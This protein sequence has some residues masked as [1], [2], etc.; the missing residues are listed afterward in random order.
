[1]QKVLKMLAVFII[2][3]PLCH[4]AYWDASVGS[5]SIHRQSSNLSFELADLC[6][7]NVSGL[8]VTPS[9]RQIAGYHSRYMVVDL[10]DVAISERTSAK[11]GELRA[12]D[13]IALHSEADEDVIR[14]IIKPKDSPFFTFEFS[15]IWPVVARADRAVIYRGV[16]INDRD[17]LSNN[18]DFAGTSF[19]NSRELSKVRYSDMMLLCMNTTVVEDN[20]DFINVA[21]LPTKRLSYQID[22]FSSGITDLRYRETAPDMVTALAEGNDRYY[23][24]Y[25]LTAKISMGTLP[26]WLN[27][28][29]GLEC[30]Q[31]DERLP[32]ISKCDVFDCWSNR[33]SGTYAA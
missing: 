20:E 23:G 25:S 21:F 32:A 8:E 22:A 7:G 24:N 1:M 9:G 26:I 29:W 17:L 16:G 11:E 19:L 5:W 18:L 10:N 28:E 13:E 27:N 12:Q 33:P 3:M 15:E 6:V 4:C 2:F 14:K 31:P 30:C